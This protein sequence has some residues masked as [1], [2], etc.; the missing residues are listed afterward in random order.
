MSTIAY[1]ASHE[2][3]APSSLLHWVKMAEEAGFDAIHSSDH[4]HPWSVRQGESGF[5]FSWLGAAMQVTTL[6]FSVVCSPGQ[7]YHPAI[8]AQA[9]ATLA[10]M[11]PGRLSVELGSGEALNECITGDAWPSSGD[12][13]QR[14]FESASIIKQLLNGEKVSYEGH[15]K[16]KE[17]KLYTLPAT[18]PL[19][20]AAAIARD[21][22]EWA[23]QWAEG[24]L[25]IAGNAED[26]RKKMKAFRSKAGNDSPVYVQFS[27][28]YGPF[29]QALDGAFDQWRSNLVS[30]EKLA[31]LS[32]PEDFDRATENI[33]REEVKEKISFV[34]DM[35]ALYEKISFCFECN[36]D[37]IILHNINPM[38]ELFIRDFG[39]YKS[40]QKKYTNQ[41]ALS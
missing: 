35:E 22:C 5:S 1:H 16:I 28:S 4:F 29:E 26:I 9:V 24:L 14:L 37:R 15:I 30:A 8:V 19:V 38:Q 2:Q 3:F 7:R 11:F 13:H 21:T 34:E 10:E 39:K 17:A 36:V 18:K 33:T 31:N 6:P 23:G 12:R 40:L 25:T 32:Q 41:L 20:F 27:F